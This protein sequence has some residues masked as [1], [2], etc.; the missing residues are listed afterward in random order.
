VVKLTSENES[1]QNEINV[2][3]AE[4]VT[5]DLDNLREENQLLGV[6]VNSLQSRISELDQVNKELV[7]KIKL[8]HSESLDLTNDRTLLKGNKKG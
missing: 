8:E 1:L 6:K 2:K 4:S 7:A 3:N 5:G